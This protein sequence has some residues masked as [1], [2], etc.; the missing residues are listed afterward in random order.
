M[1]ET[2]LLIA[3]LSAVVQLAD[4]ATP[5]SYIDIHLV[6]SFSSGSMNSGYQFRV[7]ASES[8]E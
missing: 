7:E 6:T 8:S 3:A 5:T 1:K 2:V 4:A